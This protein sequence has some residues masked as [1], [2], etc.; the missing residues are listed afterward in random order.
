MGSDIA[1]GQANRRL[2]SVTAAAPVVTLATVISAGSFASLLE[3]FKTGEHTREQPRR[4][5]PI[6]AHSSASETVETICLWFL[7]KNQ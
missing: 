2:L 3:N 4:N 6:S 1:E 5:L 7:I